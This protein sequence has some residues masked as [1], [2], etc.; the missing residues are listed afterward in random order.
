MEKRK[1]IDQLIASLASGTKLQHSNVA[2]QLY[3]I[4]R[5][6]ESA[7]VDKQRAMKYL[8][9][10]ADNGSV[11]ALYY[12][13]WHYDTGTFVRK[14]ISKAIQWYRMAADKGDNWAQVNLGE[15][16]L[17]GGRGVQKDYAQ[18][19]RL[20]RKAM[21][22]KDVFAFFNLGLCYDFG[23][24]VRKSDVL[25]C[26]YYAK[27]AERGHLAAMCNLGVI[28]VDYENSQK[29]GAMLIRRAA[30]RGDE[31]AQFN[32]GKWYEN[33]EC[34]LRRN[35]CLALKWLSKSA[36]QGYKKAANAL[37]RLHSK[38]PRIRC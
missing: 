8:R 21:R 6:G 3:W 5:N 4:F 36:A 18:A 24:G 32:L 26:K 35:R 25:A 29:T 17:D 16:Y 12:L 10:A 22:K 13:G 37:Q 9:M 15:I 23:K 31:I 30:M 2:Y 28:L 27:A 14:N 7:K 34:G 19:A 20:F 33:G 38:M 11:R 1:N